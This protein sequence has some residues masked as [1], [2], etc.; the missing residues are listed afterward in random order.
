MRIYGFAPPVRLAVAL[1]AVFAGATLVHAQAGQ[2]PLLVTA[3]IQRHA[4]IRMAPPATLVISEADIARGYVDVPTPVE[5]TV[6]SNVPQGY[7]LVFEAQ[8]DAVR[9]TLVEG[10]PGQ[11]VV[12]SGGATATRAAP[13]PG[14]WHDV[15]QL[16]FRFRLSR[17]ARAGSM[18]WPL[19][20]SM[21]AQ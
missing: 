7:T 16:R 2:A 11:L 9:E 14:M 19:Q 10:L 12:G 6:R 13:G 4:S 20:I 18:P 21:M 15:L 5:V 3:T 1:I 8:D 17:E